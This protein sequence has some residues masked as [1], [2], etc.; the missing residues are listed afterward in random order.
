MT[1]RFQFIRTH[2]LLTSIWPQKPTRGTL[3]TTPRGSTFLIP[4]FERSYLLFGAIKLIQRCRLVQ[5]RH[6]LRALVS[7]PVIFSLPSWTALS[8]LSSGCLARSVEQSLSILERK[9]ANDGLFIISTK[10]LAECVK[11]GREGAVALNSNPH[12]KG[13]K[14]PVGAPTRC[15]A[16]LKKKTRVLLTH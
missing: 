11:G 10:P 12:V 13:Y 5:G 2:L 1:L 9:L 6:R 7:T 8:L 15:V 16:W 14:S 3:Q 4:L